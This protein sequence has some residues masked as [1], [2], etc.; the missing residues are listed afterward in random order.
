MTNQK[1]QEKD[2]ASLLNEAAETIIMETT[3][4]DA[5]YK[6]GDIVIRMYKRR[7]SWVKAARVAEK[8]ATLKFYEKD[9]EAE[10]GYK[11]QAITCYRKAGKIHEKDIAYLLGK[12]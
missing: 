1:P 10:E 11:R 4:E 2:L 6:I 7:K 8:L 9:T 3:T 5:S 12:K